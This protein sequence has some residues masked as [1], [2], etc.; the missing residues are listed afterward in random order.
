MFEDL[1]KLLQ[2][3]SDFEMKEREVGPNKT[4]N[5]YYY[6]DISIH[7]GPEQIRFYK[8]ETFESISDVPKKY[9]T[10]GIDEDDNYFVVDCVP[11]D[12]ILERVPQEIKEYIVWNMEK[13]NGIARD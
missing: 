2:A 5:G 4:M 8:K 11:L 6:E 13:F 9:E 12:I 7:I 3:S 10:V 1:E